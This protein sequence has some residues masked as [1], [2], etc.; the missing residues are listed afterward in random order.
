MAWVKIFKG[1]ELKRK[2]EPKPSD[3]TISAKLSDFQKHYIDRVEKDH[4]KKDFFMAM[5][6]AKSISEIDL[7]SLFRFNLEM[8]KE[9]GRSLKE[10]DFYKKG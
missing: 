7:L 9:F 5:R 2:D 6:N 1:F 3:L 8:F 10:S 4:A